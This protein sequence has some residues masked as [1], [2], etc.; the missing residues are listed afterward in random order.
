MGR[1]RIPS[2]EGGTDQEAKDPIGSVAAAGKSQHRRGAGRPTKAAPAHKRRRGGIAV[3]ER[4]GFWH[5]HGRLRIG[6]RFKRVRESTKLPATAANYEAAEELRRKKEQD[7]RDELLWGVK[8]SVEVSIAVEQYLNRPR[9]RPVDGTTIRRL[10][11]IDRTFGPRNLD[12]IPEADWVKFVDKRM[13]GNKLSTRE[14]YIGSVL[15]FINWCKKRPRRW[16]GELPALERDPKAVKPKQRRARRVGEL[17]PELI[18]LLIEHASLH[19]KGQMAIHWST[20]ARVSSIIYGCRYCDYLAAEDRE[21]ITFHNTKPGIEVRAVVHPW[22]AAVMR[23]Y[24]NWRGVPKDLEEPL[25]VTHLHQPYADNGKSGGGQTWSAFHGMVRR[26]SATLRRTALREAAALRRQGRGAAA[27]ARWAAAQADIALLAQLTPHWFRHLL[28]TTM[29]AEGDVRSTMEQ[30]G[31]L[32]MRSVLAYTHDVPRRRRALVGQM[33]APASWQQRAAVPSVAT[34]VG[35]NEQQNLADADQR[36]A[37]P[38]LSSLGDAHAT[39]PYRGGIAGVVLAQINRDEYEVRKGRWVFGLVRFFGGQTE[40]GWRFL[41]RVHGM[42][43]SRKLHPNPEACLKGRFSI[44]SVLSRSTLWELGERNS[45][46][47]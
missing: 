11:E 12:E 15:A 18:A 45:S 39:I 25:F 9:E 41:P 34:E 47:R 8:P 29:M 38:L 5:L 19:Y 7:V 27:R 37:E 10:K 13:A 32:D 35:P 2:A 17:R 23:E 22:A 43:P 1:K 20:G 33:P 36:I 14:S 26:A 46:R 4:D 3:T 24:L 31:W 40:W 21:Q 16:V 42:Q 28:A 44:A 6:R 30:G